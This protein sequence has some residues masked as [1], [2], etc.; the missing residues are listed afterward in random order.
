MK[1]SLIKDL[2]EI[3]KVLE[4]LETCQEFGVMADIAQE[5][6]MH[7]SLHIVELAIKHIETQ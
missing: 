3:R 1:K 2:E 6:I 4:R 7:N 5:L